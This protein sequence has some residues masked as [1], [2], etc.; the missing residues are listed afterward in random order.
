MGGSSQGP[1]FYILGFGWLVC[2]SF[3]LVVV[4]GFFVCFYFVLDGYDFLFSIHWG[5]P[6]F[7]EHLDNNTI[8][9]MSK[10]QE[11]EEPAEFRSRET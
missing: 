6:V 7:Q 5:H 8:N 1:S 2:C 4:W 11:R 10:G 9:G 3:L